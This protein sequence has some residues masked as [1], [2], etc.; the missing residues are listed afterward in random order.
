V[1][2][3]T[4]L[5][6]PRSIFRDTDRRR[7]NRILALTSE[8]GRGKLIELDRCYVAPAGRVLKLFSTRRATLEGDYDNWFAQTRNR[9]SAVRGTVE[10]EPALREI[11]REAFCTYEMAPS[12]LVDYMV[13][14]TPG[15]FEE[16]GYS[17][18]QMDSLVYVFHRI[19]EEQW[20]ARHA[21]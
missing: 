18:Q 14:S 9:L 7:G 11:C 6:F 5:I 1:R 2:I 12:E 10:F 20:A 15:V 17:E 8:A 4:L 3:L 13:V 16:A 19:V 21:R